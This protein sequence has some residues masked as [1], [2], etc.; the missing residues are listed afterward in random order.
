LNGFIKGLYVL[1]S[2]TYLITH[3]SHCIFLKIHSIAII[4]THSTTMCDE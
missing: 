1:F 4:I 2:W 3:E